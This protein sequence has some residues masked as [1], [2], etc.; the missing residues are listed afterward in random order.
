[1]SARSN[2]SRF[3]AVLYSSGLKHMKPIIVSAIISSGG[4]VLAALIAAWSVRSVRGGDG[5]GD[6][7]QTTQ[8]GTSQGPR[9][10]RTPLAEERA[11]EDFEREREKQ[12]GRLA[13]VLVFILL[14]VV[15]VSLWYVLTAANAFGGQFSTILALIGSLL[16]PIVGLLGAVTGFYYGAQSA[17]QGSQTATQAAENVTQAA[18]QA[19][20]RQP[21][22]SEQPDPEQ[23][24]PDG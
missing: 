1:V 19:A 2:H 7:R 22:G 4:T 10:P 15:L 14:A 16:A 20:R 17:V 21:A 24:G 6:G 13:I 8:A 11:S 18:T 12:R 9:S 3:I 23:P 5:S